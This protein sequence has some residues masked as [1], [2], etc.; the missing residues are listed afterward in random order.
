MDTVRG[1]RC[2]VQVLRAWLFLVQTHGRG[3]WL[4][5]DAPK[6]ILSMSAHPAGC[7]RD[8]APGC[9]GR[10]SR[11]RL[12]RAAARCG[13]WLLRCWILLLCRLSPTS[14]KGLCPELYG[15]L[16]L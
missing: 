13:T 7:T 14:E 6:A 15:D 8:N 10:P 3:L 11:T 12:V 4:S 16:G 2:C 9:T 1:E 5:K